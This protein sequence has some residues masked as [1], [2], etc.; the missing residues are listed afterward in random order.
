MRWFRKRKNARSLIEIF[1]DL[2]L[3]LLL[4]IAL[5]PWLAVQSAELLA[6]LAAACLTGEQEGCLRSLA[7]RENLMALVV[8]TLLAAT[9]LFSLRLLA[10]ALAGSGGTVGKRN[11]AS[12]A[13]FLTSFT[14]LG[15]VLLLGWY[16]APSFLGEL[17][18][19]SS[20][21]GIRPFSEFS[22]GVIVL[23]S[24]VGALSFVG[25]LVRQLLLS[26][27]GEQNVEE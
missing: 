19:G 4:V 11:G 5:L 27:R 6:P 23:L 26:L 25:T 1:R 7:L 16:A 21:G 2:P 24:F 3:L 14:I 17:L 12:S 22:T 9:L 10:R 13:G 15:G 18:G 8:I 20:S